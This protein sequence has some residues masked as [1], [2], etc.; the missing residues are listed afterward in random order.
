MDT[1]SLQDPAVP[2]DNGTHQHHFSQSTTKSLPFFSMEFEKSTQYRSWMFNEESLQDCKDK[3]AS[4]RSDVGARS[5]ACGFHQEQER[6]GKRKRQE[7]Y[8]ADHGPSPLFLSPS[9]QDTLVHFHAH[10]IQRLIGPNAVFPSLRRSASILSTAIMLFRR[11][12]LSNSVLDF[13]PREIAAASALLAVKVD[14]ERKLEVSSK[15]WL[16]SLTSKI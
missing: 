10:Q 11:F 16:R 13:H 7:P 15:T 5:F 4:L 12:Y 2:H 8:S 6:T 14:C 3:A 9:D 1:R